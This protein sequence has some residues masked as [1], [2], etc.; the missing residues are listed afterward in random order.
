MRV[1]VCEWAGPV[2]STEITYLGRCQNG[3]LAQGE[4][5]RAEGRSEPDRLG[6]GR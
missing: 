1:G 3:G 2:M 4:D 6:L 5:L